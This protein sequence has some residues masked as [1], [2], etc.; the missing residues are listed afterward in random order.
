MFFFAF[1]GEENPEGT[2]TMH[3]KSL[4]LGKIK[5]NDSLAWT[6]AFAG[7]FPS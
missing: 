6:I 7:C 5:I 2:G 3:E 1:A 4:A